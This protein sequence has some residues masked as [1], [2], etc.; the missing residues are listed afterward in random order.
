MVLR[1]GSKCDATDFALPD[2]ATGYAN[3]LNTIVAT[4]FANLP[5][6]ACACS[7]YNPHP[8][9]AMLVDVRW[10]AWMKSS[11]SAVRCCPAVSGSIAVPAGIGGGG[12]VGWGEI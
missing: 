6:I 8:G 10:G 11:A 3:G 2:V 5:S 12:A 4:A 9:A 7:I 1:A